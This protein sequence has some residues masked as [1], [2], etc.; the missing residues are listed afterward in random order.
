MN[1]DASRELN[2]PTDFDATVKVDMRAFLPVGLE[3]PGDMIGRYKLVEPL[4]E[5]GFGTVWQAEQSEPI[6]REVALKVIKAG[7]DS[8]EI[9]VRFEAERQALALMDHPNIAGVLDA[10]TTDA[11]RPYFAMEL[12]KG[13]PITEY[14]DTH[15]LT[16]RQRLELFIPVCRAVQHAHQKAILHR[17]LKPSNILV[18]EVDGKAVPKVIDFGIAK[19]LGTSPEAALQ[20]SMLQTQAGV[21]IGTPQ[22]MSPEQAGATSDLDTRSDIYT[23]GVI[24]FELLTGDT[25]LSRDSLRKAALDEVLRLVREAEPKR[26]SSRVIPITAAVLQSSTDRRTEPGRLSR[27]LRGDLDWITLKALEK[28]RERRYDSAVALADDLERH[29]NN[30]PVE[31]G[32]PSSLYRF[33]KLVQRNKLAVG[34]A[35]A[36]LTMLILGIGI[37]TWQAV[38]ASRAEALVRTQKDRQD[39]MLWIASR[40][41]HE[42]AL[43]VL[44]E[45]KHAEALAFFERALK[46]RPTNSSALVASAVHAFGPNAPSWRTR[47]V[48]AFKHFPFSMSFSG[49]SRLIAAADGGVVR[50]VEA[51]TGRQVSEILMSVTNNPTSNP[52]SEAP[53]AFSPDGRYLAAGGYDGG[54]QIL[55]AQTGRQMIKAEM[56]DRVNSISFSPDG[57]CLAIGVGGFSSSISGKYFETSVLEVSTGKIISRTTHQGA[58]Y[59]VA[60][61]PRGGV[62]AAGGNDKMLHLIDALTGKVIYQKSYAARV[63][64]VRFSPDGRYLACENGGGGLAVIEASSGQA[65][66]RQALGVLCAFNPD[67]TS[68]AVSRRDS[69]NPDKAE[70]AF[71]ALPTGIVNRTIQ[72]PGAGR[73]LKYSPDGRWLAGTSSHHAVRIINTAT[74][75]DAANLYFG[76]YLYSIGF[77]PDGHYFAATG[78]EKTIR[79]FE[80]GVMDGTSRSTNTMIAGIAERGSRYVKFSSNGQR[81]AIARRIGHSSLYDSKSGNELSRIALKSPPIGISLSEDGK[82]VVLSCDDNSIHVFD[83]ATGTELSK[84]AFDTPTETMVFS[85]DGG[86]IA[87][88]SAGMVRLVSSM[89]GLEIITAKHPF[90]NAPTKSISF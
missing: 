45:H 72:F 74:G 66:F 41:D 25:P 82:L 26:P 6:R 29:L 69:K 53:L 39:E 27:T 15:Q 12:V 59:S 11:G 44:D 79:V 50:V 1:P 43:R 42:A 71:I 78:D 70:L 20:V 34:A 48:S 28:E 37:S 68:L 8:R 21:V 64:A 84:A 56:R 16:I 33:R 88:G 35:A 7:M 61:S 81:F 4:G 13:V 85:P 86:R 22:Y 65:L 23:L 30:E 46:Y 14:C 9:I 63:L 55:E 57:S 36:I 90:P 75:E 87:L 80:P 76:G 10:G 54:V 62:Y 19:A 31:A 32:P 58:V 3:Q 17:D 51:A 38:R 89:T 47:A 83:G 40:G 24:L 49:D 5:G 2:A 77:S 73:M 67:G 60:Y 52:S 18:T